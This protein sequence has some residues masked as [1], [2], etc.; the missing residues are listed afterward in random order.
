MWNFMRFV[1]QDDLMNADT[2]KKWYFSQ[3]QNEFGCSVRGSPAFFINLLQ[4]LWYE[5]N[6]AGTLPQRH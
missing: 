4:N 2:E 5:K 3:N 1:D 6:A